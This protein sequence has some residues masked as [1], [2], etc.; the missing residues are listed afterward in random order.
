MAVIPKDPLEWLTMF[1]QQMDE[2]FAYLSK[3]Q[4]GRQKEGHEYT[5]FMDIYET[6]DRYVIEFELP[7]F[8]LK[9]LKVVI[10]CNTLVV[11]GSKRNIK[12]REGRNYFCM[13]RCFGRFCR[14]V[15]IPPAVDTAGVT[16][17]YDKGVLRVSFPW[18]E[19]RSN[20]VR[21]ITIVQ[22]DDDGKQN[23]N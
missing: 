16:A 8:D 11:E 23:G 13:E 6:S 14:T 12:P 1:R 18:M 19:D 10:C 7:G 20:I 17:G 2:I 15:E 21:K 22:G 3:L 9:N 4:E 5:P